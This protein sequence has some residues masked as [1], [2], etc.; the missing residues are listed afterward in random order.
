[1][2]SAIGPAVVANSPERGG[3]RE[4]AGVVRAQAQPSHGPADYRCGG[5]GAARPFPLETEILAGG[6]G[7]FTRASSPP[8]RAMVARQGRDAKGGSVGAQ[9]R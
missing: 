7:G 9:R 1:M 2:A 8:A 5:E 4:S 6:A 3:Q